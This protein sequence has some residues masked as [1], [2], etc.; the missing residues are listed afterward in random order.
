MTELSL[1]LLLSL[2][3]TGVFSSARSYIIWFGIEFGPIPNDQVSY[4]FA[5]TAVVFSLLPIVWVIH[6]V[7]RKPEGMGKSNICREC[8][9]DLRAT[10]YRCPECGN[11]PTRD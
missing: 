5:T 6:R 11:D 4:W 2:L 1:L 9:Y 10:P 3:T 7:T 8:G